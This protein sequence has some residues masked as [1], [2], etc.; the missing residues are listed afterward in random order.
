MK[1]KLRKNIYG[2]KQVLNKI[3]VCNP[4]ISDKDM[5]LV[6]CNELVNAGMPRLDLKYEGDYAFVKSEY[7]IVKDD[8]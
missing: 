4:C 8:K 7:K 2:L 6:T 3:L 5:M 1:L